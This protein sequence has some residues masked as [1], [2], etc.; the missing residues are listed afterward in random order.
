MKSSSL[1]HSFPVC[2]CVSVD[3]CECQYVNFTV[4]TISFLKPIKYSALVVLLIL[5][6]LGCAAFIFFDKS[7]KEVSCLW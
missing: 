5:A 2:V 1:F 4:T 6:E 3:G 7:W